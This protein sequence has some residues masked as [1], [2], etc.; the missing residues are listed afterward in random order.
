MKIAGIYS[1]APS[2]VSAGEQFALKF[3]ILT[4]PYAVGSACWIKVPSL[5]GPFNFS[6]RGITYLDNVYD[7][8][9]GEI[10]IEFEQPYN[11]ENYFCIRAER[12][13]GEL[14]WSSPVW[15]EK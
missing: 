3:K 7:G 12:I 14:A 2:L 15:I 6:P 5:K 13:D 9:I 11:G 1:I 10:E 4:E 8:D